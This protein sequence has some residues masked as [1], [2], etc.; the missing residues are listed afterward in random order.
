MVHSIYRCEFSQSSLRCYTHISPYTVECS[1]S[2]CYNGDSSRE[3]RRESKPRAARLY[4]LVAL[5]TPPSS[6]STFITS[7]VAAAMQFFHQQL[8]APLCENKV[9][10]YLNKDKNRLYNG[11]LDYQNMCSKLT[12]TAST[13]WCNL[14]YLPEDLG[15]ECYY[16]IKLKLNLYSLKITSNTI[17]AVGI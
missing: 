2:A 8:P 17:T 13:F 6:L 5:H 14:V 10:R 1:M 7:A 11:V 16:L 12:F 3:C 9:V 15:V 4:A